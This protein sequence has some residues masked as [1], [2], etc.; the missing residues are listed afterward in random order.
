MANS[1]L[2]ERQWF[3]VADRIQE[4]YQIRELAA[5]LGLHRD[6]IYRNLIRLGIRKYCE[7][8]PPLDERRQEFQ[9]LAAAGE[10]Y[11]AWKEKMRQAQ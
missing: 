1:L 5:F 9:T 2:S 3:W 8:L 11:Q 4:G 6:T 7:E 10:D